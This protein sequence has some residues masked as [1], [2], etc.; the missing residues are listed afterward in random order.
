MP[1]PEREFRLMIAKLAATRGRVREVIRDRKLASSHKS[2]QMQRVRMLEKQ[3]AWKREGGFDR[4]EIIAEMHERTLRPPYAGFDSEP[5]YTGLYN[6]RWPLI[7]QESTADMN[8][9]VGSLRLDILLAQ[10]PPP[11][12]YDLSSQWSPAAGTGLDELGVPHTEN[13]QTEQE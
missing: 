1:Y 3:T 7:P 5:L 10:L 13:Q 2:E 9:E 8:V 4:I 12:K 11:P 6:L